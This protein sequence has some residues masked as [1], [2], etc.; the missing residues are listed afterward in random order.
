MAFFLLVLISPHYVMLS[1]AWSWHEMEPYI[2]FAV[3]L[4]ALTAMLYDVKA[5]YK[6]YLNQPSNFSVKFM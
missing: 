6:W 5:C 2:S 4:H 1:F 3:C